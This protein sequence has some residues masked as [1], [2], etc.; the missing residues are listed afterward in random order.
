MRMGAPGGEAS[1]PRVV[2]AVVEQK[3]KVS[4][5]AGLDDLENL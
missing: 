2:P 5:M 1:K 3:P 4:I